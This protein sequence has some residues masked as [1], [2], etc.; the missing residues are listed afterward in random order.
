MKCTCPGYCTVMAHPR[1]S[2][3]AQHLCDQMDVCGKTD[4]VP[5][6]T[7]HVTGETLNRLLKSA[8]SVD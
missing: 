5:I 3:D 6:I 2:Y 7:P 8:I 1:I 4:L